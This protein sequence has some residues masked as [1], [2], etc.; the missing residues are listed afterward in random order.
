MRKSAGSR[1][2]PRA[3][4]NSRTS[5]IAPLRHRRRHSKGA[6]T[7][8]K[9]N[10]YQ[11][12]NPYTNEWRRTLFIDW[13]THIHDPKD[14]AKPYWRG[15]CPMTLENVLAA[16]ELAGLDKTVISNAVHY[17]RFCKTV[18]ETVEALESSNRYLA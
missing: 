4:R 6:R 1:S 12:A 7:F 14:Q 13:H 10:R 15:R 3:A 17:L 11:G 16:H 18:E 9:A 2:R 8:S 5:S